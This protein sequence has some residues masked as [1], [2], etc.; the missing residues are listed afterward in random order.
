MLFRSWKPAA[1]KKACAALEATEL[2]VSGKRPR[3]GREHF[4]PGGWEEL[5]ASDL[6]LETWKAPLYDLTRDEDGDLVLPFGQILLFKPVGDVFRAA[7]ARIEAGDKPALEQIK[8]GR[9]ARAERA[10]KGK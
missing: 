9:A 1:Y 3:A 4:L 7:W 6:P 8:T 2:V 5:A 10:G